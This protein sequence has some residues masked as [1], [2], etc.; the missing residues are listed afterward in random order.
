[1]THVLNCGC[2]LADIRSW[3][4]NGVSRVGED[5]WTRFSVH[6]HNHLKPDGG[7]LSVRSGR[8][9]A[10]GTVVLVDASPQGDAPLIPAVLSCH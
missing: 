9:K 10:H 7:R 8:D 4:H 3:G 2:N 1:V 6:R 5:T